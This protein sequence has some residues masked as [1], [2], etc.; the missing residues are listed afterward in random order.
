MDKLRGKGSAFST[1]GKPW[2]PF[3]YNP[4]IAKR[5]ARLGALIKAG[6]IKPMTKAE[7]QAQLDKIHR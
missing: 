7:M 6:I 4:K 2:W 1:S 5:N 3:R